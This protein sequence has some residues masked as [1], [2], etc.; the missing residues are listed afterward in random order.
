MI[1]IVP[2]LLGTQARQRE[3]VCPRIM[4]LR[5]DFGA[6][7]PSCG[8]CLGFPGFTEHVGV[9]VRSP[10]TNLGLAAVEVGLVR[11]LTC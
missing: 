7:Y 4:I 6:S 10:N 5:Q 1:M 11:F 9:I 8:G 2:Q 3:R